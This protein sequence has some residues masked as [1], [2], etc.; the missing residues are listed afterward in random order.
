MRLPARLRDEYMDVRAV[1]RLALNRDGAVDFPQHRAADRQPQAVA[2]RLGGEERLEHPRKM[3][4]W[5]PASGIGDGDV[6]PAIARTNGDRDASAMR[7]GLT[8]VGEQIE[9][10]LFEVALA[11]GHCRDV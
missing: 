11:A 7:R 9:K 1:A 8:G 5:D 10:D 6:D 3:L 2:V 4:P